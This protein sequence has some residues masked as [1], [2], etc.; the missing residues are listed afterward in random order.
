MADYFRERARLWA[1]AGVIVGAVLTA[2]DLLVA[3]PSFLTEYAVRNDFR[4]ADAAAMVGL[5]GG[6][7]RLSDLS[8][9]ARAVRALGPEFHVPPCLSPPPLARL[10][11]H[12][13]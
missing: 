13:S 1:V 9:Q 11:T 2:W 5:D 7:A 12:P 10:G 6:Y 8:A 4:L 3:A